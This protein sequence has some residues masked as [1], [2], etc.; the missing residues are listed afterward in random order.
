MKTSQYYFTKNYFLFNALPYLL[1]VQNT[2]IDGL[3]CHELQSAVY[4]IE[5]QMSEYAL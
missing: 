2:R 4:S 1:N 3:L 5:Y